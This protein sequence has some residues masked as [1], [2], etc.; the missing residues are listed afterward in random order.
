VVNYERLLI[1]EGSSARLRVV[2]INCFVLFYLSALL[3]LGV[4][5]DLLAELLKHFSDYLGDSRSISMI[6]ICFLELSIN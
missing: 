2:L 6:E 5:L 1:I 4:R 3:L